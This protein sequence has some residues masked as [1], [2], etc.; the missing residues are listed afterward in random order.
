MSEPIL[1]YFSGNFWVSRRGCIHVSQLQAGGPVILGLTLSGRG[2]TRS[3]HVPGCYS[4]LVYYGDEY[5]FYL[6]VGTHEPHRKVAGLVLSVLEITSL[7]A[8][9]LSV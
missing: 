1:M 7:R 2:R 8:I 3:E 9:W 6:W 5:Y 4:N